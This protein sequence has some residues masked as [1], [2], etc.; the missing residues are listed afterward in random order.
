VP[1]VRYH[2]AA[3]LLHWLIAAALAFMIA[4]GWRLE[5]MP[6][7]PALFWHYQFHKSVGIA[8]LA[9]TLVR[10][11]VRLTVRRPAAEADSPW[12]KRASG[13]V[14][15]LLYAFMLGAPLTG[16]LIVSTSKIQVPTL[17]FQA[18]PLP[19]LPVAE[20]ARAGVHEAAENAHGLLAW[21]GIAL[22]ALHVAGALR[23]QFLLGQP[24]IERMVPAAARRLGFTG[25]LGWFALAA[26]L[27]GGAFALGTLYRA[28]V[29]ATPPTPVIAPP[30]PVETAAT[31]NVATPAVEEVEAEEEEEAA[32]AEPSDWTV[33][34]G[35]RLGFRAEW[36]GQAIVGRF[37]DWSADILFDPDALDRSRVRVTINLASADTAD[38]QR[39]S[40][41]QGPDFFD[42]AA[43]PRALFTASRF[44]ALGGDR[45]EARGTLELKGVKQPVTLAFTLAIRGDTATTSGSARIDRR[46]F[47]VGTG[48]WDAIADAVAIDFAFTARRR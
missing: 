48:D 10:I 5:D 30:P 27:V 41:L 12:A 42:S 26:G 44:T 6:Q 16:W 7:G 13:I 4:L 9:L 11:A 15:A 14:H 23:H 36:S 22:F 45:Y 39:D 31:A 29:A 34:P 47:N 46:A 33:Q 24:L 19:H 3:M 8:I 43:H 21:L 32:P 2:R 28:P 17:I 18:I 1:P 40:S 25:A 37:A 20:A 38:G 35:G